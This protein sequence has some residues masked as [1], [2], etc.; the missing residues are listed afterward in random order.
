MSSDDTFE[1]RYTI[2]IYEP[3]LIAELA[4]IYEKAEKDYRNKN[5]FFTR[6]IELGV[7][8]YRQEMK[9]N[10]KKN[11]AAEIE[12][13]QVYPLL[14]RYFMYSNQKFTEIYITLSVIQGIISS[15]YNI[16]LALHD[17]EKLF[18]EKIRDGFYDDLPPRFK[19]MLDDLKRAFGID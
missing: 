3:A 11:P 10:A 7:E 15:A 19:D 5:E 4:T 17:G 6:I 13:D 9:K 2:R 14:K 1:V 18:D 8:S 12:D 16:L